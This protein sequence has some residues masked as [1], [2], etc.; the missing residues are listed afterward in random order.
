MESGRRIWKFEKALGNRWW[1][2]FTFQTNTA[3]SDSTHRSASKHFAPLQLWLCSSSA[4]DNQC[5]PKCII[6]DEPV[7]DTTVNGFKTSQYCKISMICIISIVGTLLA[8]LEGYRHSFV[9][10][11][12]LRQG[13]INAVE[14]KNSLLHSLLWKYSLMQLRK[15]HIWLPGSVS[16]HQSSELSVK[17]RGQ[18]TEII[19]MHVNGFER[20]NR[21]CICMFADEIEGF[22]SLNPVWITN[23][24]QGRG[25]ATDREEQEEADFRLLSKRGGGM[26]CS[27]LRAD[28]PNWQRKRKEDQGDWRNLSLTPILGNL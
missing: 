12:N 23:P 28:V 19:S 16:K 11:S 3:N 15:D 7:N 4:L 14:K 21:L 27:G 13:Q 9:W 1:C 22:R 26:W 24:H 10:K 17:K 5:L 6:T 8:T 2:S 20:M 18:H 25:K